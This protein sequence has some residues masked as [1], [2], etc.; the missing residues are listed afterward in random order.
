MTLLKYMWGA[1]V[2]GKINC[3][4][5]T[6]TAGVTRATVT[7]TKVLRKV[8]ILGAKLPSLRITLR[9]GGDG[10]WWFEPIVVGG[11]DYSIRM[12]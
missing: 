4:G 10:D 12:I 8:E 2:C 11:F 1:Y 5:V 7:S 3:V 6:S 9:Y